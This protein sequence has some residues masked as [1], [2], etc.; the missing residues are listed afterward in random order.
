MRGDTKCCQL[1][2]PRGVTVSTLDCESS[3]RGSNPREAFCK[4]PADLTS[5]GPCTTHA[6]ALLTHRLRMFTCAARI[7]QE[8]VHEKQDCEVG[9]ESIS[10]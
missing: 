6:A 9:E 1:I 3:D 5:L 4:Y 8:H 2:W 7:W 10:I